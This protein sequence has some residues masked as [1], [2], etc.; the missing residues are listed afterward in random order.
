MNHVDC[1]REMRVQRLCSTIATFQYV[2]FLA[3]AMAAALMVVVPLYTT[4]HALPTQLLAPLHAVAS[5]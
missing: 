3:C 1:Q 2:T 4:L 5:R